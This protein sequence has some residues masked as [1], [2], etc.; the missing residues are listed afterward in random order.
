MNIYIYVCIYIHT[1]THQHCQHNVYKHT[2]INTYTHTHIITSHHSSLLRTGHVPQ[3][4]CIH[5]YTHTHT[6]IHTSS[7]PTILVFSAP[8]MSPRFH[9]NWDATSAPLPPRLPYTIDDWNDG[10]DSRYKSILK[11]RRNAL[12]VVICKF[13]L[14]ECTN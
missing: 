13:H 5:V 8:A 10:R 6:Y 14:C 3:I 11:S 4:P 12:Y 1:Y 2:Y 9:V 7:Q